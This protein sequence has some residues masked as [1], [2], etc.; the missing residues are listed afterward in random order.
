MASSG[1]V[2][3]WAAV[4]CVLAG[5]AAAAS[6]EGQLV[7]LKHAPGGKLYVPSGANGVH[8]LLSQVR[9]QGQGNPTRGC[10]ASMPRCRTSVPAL[11]SPPAP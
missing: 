10:V 7:K 9:P 11:P 6:G 1:V 3:R 4:L 5:V 2:M 8:P